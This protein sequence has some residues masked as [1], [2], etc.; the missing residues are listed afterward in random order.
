MTEELA[1]MKRYIESTGRANVLLER[2]A[3]LLVEWNNAPDMPKR[4]HRLHAFPYARSGMGNSEPWSCK[5]TDKQ[6]EYFLAHPDKAEEYF[7]Y[8]H[9]H[10]SSAKIIFLSFDNIKGINEN[11]IDFG[12]GHFVDFAECVQSY[13]RFHP[14]NEHCIGERDIT[15]HPPF[16]EFQ[17]LCCRYR[18]SFDKRG[19]FSE[20]KNDRDF[21]ELCRIIRG[22]GYSTFDLS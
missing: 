17:S 11:G 4:Y 8:K 19:L 2:N 14:E 12:G 3:F 10:F 13:K 7:K 18:V 20:R 16:V 5:I 1:C 6:A 22:Y 9:S 21:H 15:A